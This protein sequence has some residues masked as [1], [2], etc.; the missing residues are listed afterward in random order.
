MKTHLAILLLLTTIAVGELQFPPNFWTK[1]EAKEFSDCMPESLKAFKTQI[2]AERYCL[3]HEEHTRWMRNHP[4]VTDKKND[5]DAMLA[6]LHKH[7]AKIN[8]SPQQFRTAWD[9]C[10]SESYGLSRS[11]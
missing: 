7:A 1:A 8:G 4:E 3:V 5:S 2:G 6:C 11:K 9:A 10:M